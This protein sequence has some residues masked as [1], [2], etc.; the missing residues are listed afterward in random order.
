MGGGGGWRVWYG[1][2]GG[3]GREKMEGVRVGGQE[4]R[5][6]GKE[7]EGGGYARRGG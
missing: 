6:I 4:M 3:C 7:R 1:K 2:G 5:G